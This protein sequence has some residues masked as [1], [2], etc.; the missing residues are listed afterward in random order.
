MQRRM[1]VRAASAE[2]CEP[3]PSSDSSAGREG[4]R[5]AAP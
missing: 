5:T 2:K 3:E 4:S 1:P